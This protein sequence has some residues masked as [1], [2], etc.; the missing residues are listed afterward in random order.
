MGFPYARLVLQ[1]LQAGG[2]FMKYLVIALAMGSALLSTFALAQPAEKPLAIRADDPA[3]AWGPCPPVFPGACTIAV[4]HGNPARPNADVFLRVGLGYVL[5]PHLHTSAERITLVS[6]QLEVQYKGNP[7]A[8]LDPGNY[9]F[10]PAGMP[11]KGRCL[12]KTPCT[13]FIAF[14]TPVDAQAVPNF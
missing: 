8:R 13:L 11:H 10:G 5:P 2:K 1:H 3:L 7:V 4:L 6:G 12:S 14:E 9:A